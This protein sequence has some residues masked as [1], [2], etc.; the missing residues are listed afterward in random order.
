M[1]GLLFLGPKQYNYMT[2]L[3]YLSGMDTRE[4]K[5]AKPTRAMTDDEE[6]KLARGYV[7]LPR[8]RPESP[9]RRGPERDSAWSM[10]Q[11]GFRTAKQIQEWNNSGGSL[12]LCCAI[13]I[14]CLPSTETIV[15]AGYSFPSADTEQLRKIFIEGVLDSRPKLVVVNPSNEEDEFHRRVQE[16]FPT[17]GEPDYGRK[18]FKEF[19]A[20]L[21]VGVSTSG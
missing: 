1:G 12:A 17:L 7:Y 8:G 21:Q 18:D 2:G 11:T 16:V 19:C 3:C 4:P 13:Y 15:V 20:D 5:N 14:R 9:T 10:V 6:A